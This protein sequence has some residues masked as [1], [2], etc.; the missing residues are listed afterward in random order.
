MKFNICT[1]TDNGVGLQADAE[2][3]RDLLK[4]WGHQ[5]T[6]VHYKKTR[7]IEEAQRADVNL[8]LEVIAY[9]LLNRAPNNWL[10]PNPEWF[11]PCDHCP[12]MPQINR[13]LCKTQDAVQIF[14]DLYGANRVRHIGFE[15]RDLLDTGVERR[16]RFLHVAGQSRYKNSKAVAYAFAKFFG[17]KSE[18]KL[19]QELV[20][21]GAYPEEVEFARD[22]K[23]VTYIQRASSA[24]L[25]QLMNEC[26]FHIMPS[27][28]E[29]WGHVIH[30]GLGC[31]A[32]VVSTDHPPMNEFI[33]IDRE[34]LIKPQKTFPQ[35]SAMQAN[36]GAYEVRAMIEK[37]LRLTPERI[38]AISNR[39]REYFLSQ[40]DEFRTKFK[41]EMENP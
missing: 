25:K 13:I 36:V 3:L 28:T 40:R 15:S 34:L 30:E 31:G 33:G 41:K 37:A 17:D 7:E 19:Y 24:E 39:A 14:S 23:N 21:V 6:L 10:I 27:G 4:S 5:V 9:G 1:N 22:A 35:L 11:V 29:G 32:V 20:F 8:F 2:L 18:P 26:Q 16:R 12:G 38:S